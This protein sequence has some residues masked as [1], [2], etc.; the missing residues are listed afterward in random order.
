[1]ARANTVAVVVPS[2]ATSE[3]LLA[4]SFTIWAPMFSNLSSSSTSLATVTPSFVMF[5]APND[6]SRTTLRP[7]GPS[8]TVTASARMLTPWS[9]FSRASLPNLT[10]FAPI[11]F[12]SSLR[13]KFESGRSLDHAEDVVLAQDQVLLALVLVLGAGILAEQDSVAGFDVQGA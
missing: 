10:I 6:F 11:A 7:F 5:G 3:V 8:V 9:T 2:P 12:N 4:T 1:M 13:S